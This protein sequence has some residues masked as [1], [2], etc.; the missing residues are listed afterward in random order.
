MDEGPET[1]RERHSK[2]KSHQR[3]HHPGFLF[4][5]VKESNNDEGI[6][7]DIEDIKKQINRIDIAAS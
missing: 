3:A 5:Q 2:V 6:D 1:T 7:S 4:S